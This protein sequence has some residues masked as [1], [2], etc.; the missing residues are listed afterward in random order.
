MIQLIHFWKTSSP[1]FFW[2]S[3]NW[4]YFQQN[5]GK[6]AGIFF[7]LRMFFC[8]WT[9]PLAHTPLRMFHIYY[10]TCPISLFLKCRRLLWTN[11][12]HC[13]ICLDIRYSSVGIL[14]TYLRPVHLYFSPG[15]CYR[16][17]WLTTVSFVFS[18]VQTGTSRYDAIY[19][20]HIPP[21]HVICWLLN[22]M[23]YAYL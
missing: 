21:L 11:L 22:T 9:S 10:Y 7:L 14:L 15:V 19:M 13:H 1:L 2:R 17:L 16:C 20:W 8:L 5:A 12:N 6:D 23:L 3:V 18:S 4:A